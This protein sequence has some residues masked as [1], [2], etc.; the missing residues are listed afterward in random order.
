MTQQKLSSATRSLPFKIGVAFAI[1]LTLT[2]LACAGLLTHSILLEKD[3]IERYQRLAENNHARPRTRPEV[4]G[5]QWK[6]GDAY[7]LYRLAAEEH[8][9][10][11]NVLYPGYDE[12]NDHI[13][14]I[15]EAGN[16]FNHL[17]KEDRGLVRKEAAPT[18]DRM[19]LNAQ[20]SPGAVLLEKDCQTLEKLRPLLEHI[21]LAAQTGGKAG[22]MAVWEP[23]TSIDAQTLTSVHNAFGY[24]QSFAAI[25]AFVTME[26]D[27]T[28]G[29]RKLLRTA[30]FSIDFSRG[31]SLLPAM[32]GVMLVNR[33]IAIMTH[34]LEQDSLNVAQLEMV[35]EQTS[36]LDAFFTTTE[37]FFETQ[38]IDISRHYL[39][40]D[41]IKGPPNL[42]KAAPQIPDN[43]LSR[44]HWNTTINAMLIIWEQTVEIHRTMNFPER[45][46][47]YEE[48]LLKT[49]DEMALRSM[50]GHAMKYDREAQIART[51]WRMLGWAAAIRLAQH[52]GQ[53]A[54]LT[55]AK[56]KERH[57]ELLGGTFMNLDPQM[58]VDDGNIKLMASALEH[59]D[60]KNYID[61]RVYHWDQQ[62]TFNLHKRQQ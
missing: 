9:K 22:P 37:E 18:C 46:D 30:L 5:V 33:P 39:E 13:E 45:A 35:L 50:E 34:L 11:I 51:R 48:I 56:L 36:I 62:L 41:A 20:D 42:S 23:W 1:L 25:D 6:A 55:I 40:P 38:A 15:K 49:G 4:A 19:G 47:E 54:G 29:L 21:H 32:V 31:A 44:Y 24:L 17:S 3:S 27:M 12:R 2:L 61:N 60:T 7:K 59:P 43:L 26:T 16:S 58:T 28:Q 53:D 52:K 10:L 57:P 8:I 14:R